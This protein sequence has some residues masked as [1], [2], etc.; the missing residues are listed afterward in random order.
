M[1]RSEACSTVRRPA[2]FL[3]IALAVIAL[4]IIAIAAPKAMPV[5]WQAKNAPSKPL[6]PGTKFTV[7]LEAVIDPGWHLYALEEPK[8]G[9]TATEIALTE[10]DAADLL[11]VDQG[12]P[13]VLPDPV[14]Q[15]PTGFFETTATFTLYLQLAPGATP[16]PHT[17][18][19]LAKYQSC[20]DRLC[21]PPHTDTIEIPVTT[22]K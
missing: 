10:G 9:P 11:R 19:V 15:Q 3:A 13:K 18:H 8:G 22:G 7:I 14:F 21:L 17:L 1:C 4:P 2:S 12:K 16:G 5:H 20:N 6:K